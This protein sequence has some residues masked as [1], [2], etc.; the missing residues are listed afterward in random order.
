MWFCKSFCRSE[1]SLKIGP[2]KLTNSKN[3]FFTE[4]INVKKVA[5]QKNGKKTSTYGTKAIPIDLLVFEKST[6]TRLLNWPFF[7]TYI[8][9]QRL[10]PQFLLKLHKNT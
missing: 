9:S 7:T 8:G 5:V 1:G 2:S 10:F 4:V 6:K 3:I